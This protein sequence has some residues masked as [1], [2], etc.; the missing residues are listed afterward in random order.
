MTASL[1]N[2]LHVED[3]PNDALLFQHACRKAGVTFSLQAV[4]DGDEAI[5]YLRG[6]QDFSDG[7]N[8]PVPQLVRLDLKM[9]RASVFDLLSWLREE[10]HFRK[11]PVIVL[12]SSNHE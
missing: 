10:P 5:A 4:N 3:D 1:I 12:T 9:P 6:Q 8:H 11:L 2:I 7:K